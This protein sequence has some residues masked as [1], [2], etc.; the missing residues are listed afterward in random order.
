MTFLQSSIIGC[1]LVYSL[2]I[3]IIHIC[4]T[5]LCLPYYFVWSGSL[6]LS[7]SL[8]LSLTHTHTHTYTHTTT[9]TTTNYSLEGEKWR[10]QIKPSKLL[11][12][13]FGL[14]PYLSFLLMNKTPVW[15]NQGY[16]NFPHTFIFNL[17]FA[18]AL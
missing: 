2:S 5:F 15:H 10:Q 3:L 11:T 9:T 17:Y 8:S 14:V 13:H 1:I 7:D 4:H 6:C 18:Y 16:C 12:R